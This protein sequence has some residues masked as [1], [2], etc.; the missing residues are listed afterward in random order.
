M[1]GGKGG[2]LGSVYPLEPNKGL[3]EG[4]FLQS[5]EQMPRGQAAGGKTGQY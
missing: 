4:A 5:F 2:P 3:G 1:A